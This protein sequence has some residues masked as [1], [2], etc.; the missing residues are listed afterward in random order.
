ML[1][2]KRMMAI[3]A[4]ALAV[5]S[6]VWFVARTQNK[7][8]T[9]DEFFDVEHGQEVSTSAPVIDVTRVPW[10]ED[11]I[12]EESIDDGKVFRYSI[13]SL[14]DD[15]DPAFA[16]TEAEST[17][18]YHIY[19]GLYRTVVG[20]LVPAG[21][22]SVDISEDGLTYTFHLNDKAKW[23]DGIAVKADDYVYGIRR[24][25]DPHLDSPTA[26]L[27]D[28]VKNGAA[29]RKGEL[30]PKELGVRSDGDNTLIIELDHPAEYFLYMLQTGAFCPVRGDYVETYGED[31]CT[32]SGKQVYNGP[33][34]VR[35]TAGKV[36]VLEKNPEYWGADTV[37]LDRVLIQTAVDGDLATRLYHEG[38]L[39]YASLPSSLASGEPEAIFY[40]EGAIDYIVPNLDNVY[41]AN[42]NLRLAISY[43]M[44][45]KSISGLSGNE[46]FLRFVPPFVSGIDGG[47]YGRLFPYEAVPES[48]NEE[49]AKD[50]LRKALSELGCRAKDIRL[51]AVTVDNGLCLA[52]AMR[53]AEQVHMVLGIRIDLVTVPYSVRNAMMRPHSEEF[54][55]LFTGWIPEYPDALSFLE[56]FVSDSGM[57]FSNYSSLTYDDWLKRAKTL[58]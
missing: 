38:V 20:E 24:N 9:T 27:G 31:F 57:N 1:G 48:G 17:I 6:L 52:E 32:C 43:A 3:A 14:I 47:T 26:Y 30:S 28:I 58:S 5:L 29:V 39:D 7:N 37:K 8:S 36:I 16:D 46:A 42:K 25:M 41:L 15:L 51:R 11:S 34:Y 50:Y 40:M 54:D 45:R 23:S 22:T 12:D 49:L 18:I 53:F 44:D 35:S 19:E 33:F 2:I 55:L 13:S 56:P 21:A 4:L 10:T